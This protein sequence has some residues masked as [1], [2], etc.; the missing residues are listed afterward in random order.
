MNSG[1]SLMRSEFTTLICKIP[2]RNPSLRISKLAAVVL[3]IALFSF[4]RFAPTYALSAIS[5]TP[6]NVPTGGT[7]TI[8]I[9]QSVGP[10][11]DVFSALTVTDP[12]GNV[13][14]YSGTPFGVS[15]GSPALITFPDPGSWTMT[16]GPGG[17]TGGTDVSGMYM[18]HGT[19]L[20]TG[21]TVLTGHFI[22]LSDHGQ[23]AVPEFGQSILLLLGV[24]LPALLFARQR[25]SKQP[26]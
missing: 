8:T 14:A 6:T 22:V 19:Y 18:V 12:L 15:S 1:F 3:L 2:E 25:I 21:L 9:T 26:V 23:F 24:M 11:P 4:A 17:N 13:F 20:D 10:G 5:L 7:V 16:S